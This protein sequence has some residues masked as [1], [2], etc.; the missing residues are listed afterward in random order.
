MQ[1]ITLSSNFNTLLSSVRQLLIFFIRN[2]HTHNREKICYCY[3]IHVTDK[4]DKIYLLIA[5]LSYIQ[6]NKSIQAI[7][8]GQVKNLK[9]IIFNNKKT[10]YNY[11]YIYI[12]IYKTK[13]KHLRIQPNRLLVKFL[14]HYIWRGENKTTILI[15]ISISQLFHLIK[16][17]ISQNTVKTTI[18]IDKYIS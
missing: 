4:F 16:S 15:N 12:Y 3:L 13:T 11:N 5:M 18:P 14:L 9:V 8:I 1:D 7:D 2:K 17:N 6:Y 10:Y